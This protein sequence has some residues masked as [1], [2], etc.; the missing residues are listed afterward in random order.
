MLREG[1]ERFS[2]GNPLKVNRFGMGVRWPV[3]CR[4]EAWAG[5]KS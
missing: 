1:R 4:S 5:W 3:D 2:G